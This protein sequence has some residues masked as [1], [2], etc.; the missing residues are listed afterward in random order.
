MKLSFA[1]FQNRF[2]RFKSL[3]APVNANINK[4]NTF[5]LPEEFSGSI[6][7]CFVSIFVISSKKAHEFLS[8]HY[9]V[10][11][12]LMT[13]RYAPQSPEPDFSPC[14]KSA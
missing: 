3:Y 8:L 11:H 9:K 4:W 10:K 5:P 13:R 14:L 1:V 6:L 7:I 2:E 12:C